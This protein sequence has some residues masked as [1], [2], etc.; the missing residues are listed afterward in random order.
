MDSNDK[1]RLIEAREELERMT[2]ED[3]LRDAILL[4]FANKQDLPS[5]CSAAEVMDALG[6]HGMTNRQVGH[7]F[8][9]FLSRIISSSNF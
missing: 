6:L 4:V 8:N 3:E 2:Q 5:A 9:T 1:E 7:Y